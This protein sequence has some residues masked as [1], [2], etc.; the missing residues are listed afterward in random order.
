MKKMGQDATLVNIIRYGS[1]VKWSNP[2]KG[3]APSTKP[4]EK[5]AVASPSTK[6]INFTFRYIRGVFNKF[7]DFLYRHL[8]LS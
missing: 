6:V 3:V 5:G 2:R 7:P 1:R 4:H 8:K